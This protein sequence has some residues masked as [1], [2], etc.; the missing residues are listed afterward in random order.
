MASVRL[1]ELL[2]GADRRSIGRVP[3]VLRIVRRRPRRVAELVTALEDPSAVVR[4]R[5]ADALEKASAADP[6]LLRA[7]AR[8]LLALA[9]HARQQE[10]RWHLA[11]MLPRLPLTAEQRRQA[12]ASL[13]SYLRDRSSIVRTFA[14]QA[15]ADLAQSDAGLRTGV[16]R[17]L[18]RLASTGTPAMRARGRRLLAALGVPQPAA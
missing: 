1:R 4:M 15:L 16:V 8:T 11:Q 9:R 3:E 6:G 5:A 13:G 10:L 2:V 17:R 14:M 7:H 18:R 12:A